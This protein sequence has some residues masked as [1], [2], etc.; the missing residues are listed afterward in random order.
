MASRRE[1]L[2]RV[3]AGEL[4]PAEAADLLDAAPDEAP[5]RTEPPAPTPGGTATR[6]RVVGDFRSAR[7]VG[8]PSVAEAVADGP[9]TVHRDGDTLV[10]EAESDEPRER[11]WRFA[12]NTVV[13]GLGSKPKPLSVRMNPD[14]PLEVRIDAGS[15]SIEG[16]RAPISGDIDAGALRIRGAASPFDL[17]VDAGSVSVEGRLDH[18]ES[19]IKCDAGSVKVL[20]EKG[21]S[22]RVR[23][24][25]DVGHVS[26]GRTATRGVSIGGGPQESVFGDGEA[27][28]TIEGGIGKIKVEE[29]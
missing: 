3:A 1:I 18:G 12:R 27:T 4:T 24:H 8:D 22:V 5:A 29:A 23:A 10:I 19:R 17:Q 14:L 7:I 26:V 2:Q 25:A 20:L 28:L 21:S 6:I 13:I 11:E 9:H 16:V 15:A